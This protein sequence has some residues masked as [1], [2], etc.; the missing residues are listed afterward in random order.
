MI[1]PWNVS[2]EVH[3]VVCAYLGDPAECMECGFSVPEPGARQD[4][5]CGD[6]C[7]A[8]YAERGAA[9]EAARLA[10][11]AREDAFAVEGD[12]LRKLGHT[13]EEIDVLLAGMPT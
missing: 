5:F 7:A 2:R 4:R 9:M 13:D 1:P 10:R 6:D 12:R 3:H 8:G 11:R